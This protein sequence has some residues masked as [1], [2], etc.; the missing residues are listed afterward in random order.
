MKMG[1]RMSPGEAENQLIEAVE[2]ATGIG[3]IEL[4]D[5]MLVASVSSTIAN[6]VIRDADGSPERMETSAVLS[7]ACYRSDSLDAKPV[8]VVP[9][10]VLNRTELIR[11]AN[12]ALELY[13]LLCDH[14][15]PRPPDATAPPVPC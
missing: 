7:L 6:M 10:V 13:L 8:V 3:N 4:W 14:Q 9:R 1:E 11:L 15:E 12:Q 5:P 2:E